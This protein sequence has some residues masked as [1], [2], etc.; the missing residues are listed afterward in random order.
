MAGQTGEK[1]PCGPS[2]PPSVKAVLLMTQ[3]PGEFKPA[4]CKK[5]PPNELSLQRA[6][7]GRELLGCGQ[8]PSEARA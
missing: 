7:P 8:G 6:I 5:E 1:K 3:H 2:A 4:D